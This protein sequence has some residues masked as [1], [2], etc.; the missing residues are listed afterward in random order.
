MKYK[1]YLFLLVFIL[2]LGINNVS[3]KTIDVDKKIGIDDK[4]ILN[5]A[6]NRSSRANNNN[7]TTTG[8]TGLDVDGSVDCNEIFGS[9]NDPNSIAYLVNEILLYPK[10]IVPI[11]LVLY[12]TIDFFKAVT[13]GKEDEMKKAQMTFVK[14][15]IV[16]VGIFLVPLFINFIMWLADIAWSGLG[17]TTC[18]I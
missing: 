3:A 5:L 4:T 12:G 10:Y 17:Y 2:F 14:R 9:R 6:V 18:G 15:L 1:K 7:Y 13:A 16:G 11:L 8:N